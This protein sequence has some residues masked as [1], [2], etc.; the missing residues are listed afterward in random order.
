MAELTVGASSKEGIV[1]MTGITLYRLNLVNGASAIAMTLI[2]ALSA[3]PSQAQT[4]AGTDSTLAADRDDNRPNEIVVTANKRSERL[5]DV[6]SSVSAVSGEELDKRQIID[7]QD[8]A[9]AVPGVSINASGIST[10][11]TIRGLSSSGDGATVA[12]VLDEVPLSFSGA[13]TQG[14]F[15][16]SDFD[17]YDLERIEVLRGPQGTLYGA[18]AEG[19]LIKY[20]TKRPQLG[21]WEGGI[22]LGA[23]H[24][25]HGEAAATA[26]GYLNVPLGENA[27]LRVTAFYASLPGFVSNA[28]LDQQRVNDGERYGG[29]ASILFEPTDNLTIRTTALVQRKNTNGSEVLRVLGDTSPGNPFQTVAGY[30]AS[31]YSNNSSD[32]RLRLFSLDAAYDAGWGRLQSITSYG[33]SDNDFTLDRPTFPPILSSFG[34]PPS[35]VTQFDTHILRKLNQEVRVSSQP[36]SRLYDRDVS[37]QLGLFYTLERV[38]FRQN[39]PGRAYPTGELLPPPFDNVASDSAPSRFRDIAAFGSVDYYFFP[40]FDIE[41]GGRISRNRQRSQI[42]Q[43]GLLFSGGPTILLPE[44]LTAETVKTYSVA[45][46]YHVSPDIIGY[47]RVASGYRP[48]GPQFPIIGQPAGVPTSFGADSTTNYELGI[49]GKALGNLLTFDLAAFNI[50]W[51]DIQI[52]QVVNVVNPVTGVS[53]PYSI[54]GNAGEAVSRGLEWTIT[55]RPIADLDLQSTG[56]YT[57]AHLSETP[58]AGSAGAKGDRLPYVPE[59]TSTFSFDYRPVVG[60]GRASLGGSWTYTS[61]RQSEFVLGGTQTRLPPYHDLAAFLGYE[62]DRFSLQIYGK[63]L[64]DSRGILNYAGS[65]ALG[66]STSSTISYGA[67]AI[68]R[69]RT[70]GIRLTADF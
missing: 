18:T 47:A 10:K 27:A 58:P 50:S 60:V 64:T 30:D 22:E 33:I 46:R 24:I 43:G 2:A 38:S 66:P 19:G 3:S 12:T 17:T 53:T 23:L 8:I 42:E 6:A 21:V 31:G 57:D 36:N 4:A 51:N 32:N 49:K 39:F 15:L 63:N 25:A 69:P 11:I 61:S 68:T 55:L 20:V 35:Q 70:F 37:W 28:L 1:K 13:N 9:K 52:L 34:L 54:T 29:R 7:L 48:G 67:I 65:G 16:A 45:A 40:N 56:A 44:V 59:F 14:G 62:W 5:L 26:K 41:V